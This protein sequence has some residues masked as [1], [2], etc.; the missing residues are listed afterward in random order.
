MG[1]VELEALKADIAEHGVR[2]PIW[3][4]RG[5]LLDGRQRACACHELD[6]EWEYS[7]DEKLRLLIEKARKCVLETKQ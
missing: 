6:I 5:Y 3:T 1:A 7:R 4:W 2:Q